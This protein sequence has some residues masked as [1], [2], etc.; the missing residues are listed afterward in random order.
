MKVL[1]TIYYVILLLY[2]WLKYVAIWKT[3]LAKYYLLDLK[4]SSSK[5]VL[6]MLYKMINFLNICF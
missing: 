3:N 4:I 2:N 5:S 1:S 6:K